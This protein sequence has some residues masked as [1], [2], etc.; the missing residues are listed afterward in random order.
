MRIRKHTS[1]FEIRDSFS[2]CRDHPLCA[3][4]P[5]SSSWCSCIRSPNSTEHSSLCFLQEHICVSQSFLQLHLMTFSRPSDAGGSS[6]ILGWRRFLTRSQSHLSWSRSPPIS[7]HFWTALANTPE[8]CGK[9]RLLFQRL[10]LV[11]GR[12]GDNVED[13]FIILYEPCT[14]NPSPSLFDA[15][16]FL[17]EANK[18]HLA[19]IYICYLSC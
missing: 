6:V 13:N 7:I 18:N 16:G 12:V 4:W 9:T 11:A 8:R 1:P 17:R 19:Y 15:S 3:T 10:I 2:E 14:Y 5:S